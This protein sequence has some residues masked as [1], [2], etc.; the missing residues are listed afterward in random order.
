MGRKME[1]LV[2][3]NEDEDIID[4]VIL[5]SE[6]EAKSA[7]TDSNSPHP[8]ELPFANLVP[9]NPNQD[10]LVEKIEGKKCISNRLSGFFNQIG[11]EK[12]SKTNECVGRGNGV[13]GTNRP[14]TGWSQK[15]IDQ[16]KRI[17]RIFGEG[18]GRTKYTESRKICQSNVEL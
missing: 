8:T 4:D 6:L 15:D 2:A 14:G 9:E 1:L 5:E 7:I 12:L 17:G 10:K 11:L 16:K 3:T 13:M 18:N